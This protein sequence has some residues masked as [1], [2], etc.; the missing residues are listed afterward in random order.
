MVIFPSVKVPVLSEQITD[1]EPNVSTAANF[2]TRTS[3]FTMSEHPIEREIVTQSGIPSGIAATA[4]VTAM[5]I[6][7]NHEGSSLL[8]GSLVSI[9]HPMT[10][11]ARQTTIARTPI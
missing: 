9:V 6:M 1:A 7:Y 5:R 11:T 3:F 8:L 10:N 2:R 4:R